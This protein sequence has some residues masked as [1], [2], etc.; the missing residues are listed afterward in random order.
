MQPEK[1]CLHRQMKKF[2]SPPPLQ[3]NNGPSLNVEICIDL[4]QIH[5]AELLFGV[6]RKMTCF[7]S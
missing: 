5:T 6:R 4:H 7:F 2:S 1:N 3:K